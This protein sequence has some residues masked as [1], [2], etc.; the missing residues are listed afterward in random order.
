MNNVKSSSPAVARLRE[1]LLRDPE[2]WNLRADLFDA[3]LAAGE[4]ETARAEVERALAARPA[5]AAWRNRQSMLLLATRQYPQAQAALEALI[6]E[7]HGNPVVRYNLAYALFAQGQLEPASALLEP[8]LA[9]T[10]ESVGLAWTLWLRCQHRLDR[11]KEAVDAFAAALAT[12]RPMPPDAFGAASL[13]AL[14][15]ARLDEA[16]AWSER[17]LRGRTDQLEALATRGTLALAE[18]DAP[19]SL[20]WFDAALRVNPKD[21]RTWSGVAFARMLQMDFAGAQDA[22]RKAVA[23][24]PGHVGTWVGFGWCQFLAN[25]IDDARA[26]FEE[27]LRL[28]RN[29]AESHGG[30]AVVL[31]KMGET[32][33]ARNEI[34]IALRLD[35]KS[36]SARYAEAMLNGQTSDPKAFLRM[37]RG[38]LSRVPASPTAAGPTLAD[39]LLKDAK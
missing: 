27:A 11:L 21:G 15:E 20:R 9:Q 19:S 5:D 26:S 8:L 32:Q 16:R 12:Q 2:N 36:L 38:L 4:L 29:F 25:R 34:E 24:L 30:M 17:A 35:P 31:A 22:F 14:D 28:D 18:Q 23:N 13:M 10:D 33:R 39:V 37:A 6:A 7:G 3:A 1:Y